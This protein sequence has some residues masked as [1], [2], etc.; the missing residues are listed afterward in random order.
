MAEGEVGSGRA[1]ECHAAGDELGPDFEHGAV[2]GKWTSPAMVVAVKDSQ[3]HRRLAESQGFT[4]SPVELGKSCRIFSVHVSG[5][6]G[7]L[8]SCPG[9]FRCPRR[10]GLCRKDCS[11]ASRIR[12]AC[13]FLPVRATGEGVD[14]RFG[15]AASGG[16]REFIDGSTA[17]LTAVREIATLVRCAVEVTGWVED[18]STVGRGAIRP[19]GKGVEN[20]FSP[21]AAGRRREFVDD[22]E[23]GTAAR[24]GAVKIASRIEH[25]RAFR[26]TSHS[27]R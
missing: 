5:T 23:S 10:E 24:R 21:R 14:G 12:P 13:G 19:V 22:S 4:P 16:R 3:R 20:G 18:H 8:E 9:L 1:G 7:K 2:T 27:H 26:D 6:G 17:L 15:P 11:A 25:D